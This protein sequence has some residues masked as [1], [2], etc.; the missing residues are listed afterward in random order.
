MLEN[1]EL[2]DVKIEN[3]DTSFTHEVKYSYLL[4][5]IAIGI[6]ISILIIIFFQKNKSTFFASLVVLFVLCLTSFATILITNDKNLKKFAFNVFASC[7]SSCIVSISCF[8]IFL[9]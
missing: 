1:K 2:E 4:Y 3:T 6:F 8:W 9:K 7:S 5:P